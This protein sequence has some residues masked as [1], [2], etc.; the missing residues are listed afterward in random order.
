MPKG[1]CVAECI[2]NL[3][4]IYRGNGFLDG[5]SLMRLF[6]NSVSGDREMG[7]IVANAVNI[8]MNESEKR[9]KFF[10]F[11]SDI[12]LRSASARTLAKEIFQA[13]SMK[14]T[15]A[16]EVLC[17]PISGYVLGCVNTEV[18]R[19]CPNMTE[20]VEC[21]AL[22]NYSSTCHISSRYS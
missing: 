13:A 20:S 11:S 7:D 19:R 17:H 2:A 16:G 21:S 9:E 14:A 5:V 12:F 1:N 8:C 18:F 22:K 15:F 4:K 3:T 10:V 6:L